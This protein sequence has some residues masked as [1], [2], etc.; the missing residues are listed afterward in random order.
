LSRV[1]KVPQTGDFVL[2]ALDRTGLYTTEPA[3]PGFEQ[4]AVNL[5]DSNES[6][7]MPAARAPGDAQAHVDVVGAKVRKELW[8][9]IVAWAALPL[10]LLEW[11]VYTRRVHM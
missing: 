8:W 3:V 6:N 10:L 9:W 11:W 7:L 4:I 5:L 1:L 2:P